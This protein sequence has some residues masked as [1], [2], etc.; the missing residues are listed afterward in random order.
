MSSNFATSRGN[1]SRG[2]FAANRAGPG[3]GNFARGNFAA[4]NNFA[5]NNWNRRGD[6]R[7]RHRGRFFGPGIGFAF[8]GFGPDYYD[9]YGADDGYDD[10]CFQ[11]QFVPTPYGWRWQLVDVCQ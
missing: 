6:W 8:G 7:F 5:A 3:R 2:N 1:F 10:G 4:H 11:R 9:Y